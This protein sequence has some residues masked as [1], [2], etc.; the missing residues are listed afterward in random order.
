MA[1]G[2]RVR[3]ECTLWTPSEAP[4]SGFG[5]LWTHTGYGSILRPA[6]VE[7]HTMPLIV[8]GD[9]NVNARGGHNQR[10]L[11]H[12]GSQYGLTLCTDTNEATSRN[13]TTTD[14]IFSRHVHNIQTAACVAYFR[15]QMP[16]ATLSSG[17]NALAAVTWKDFI[18][19]RVKFSEKKAV[20]VTRSIANSLVGAMTGPLLAIFFLG[21]FF[22]FCKRKGVTAGAL[23]GV[24]LASWHALGS[25]AYPRA[26]YGLPT[27]TAGCVDFNQTLTSGSLE[28]PSIPSGPAAG[29]RER[30]PGSAEQPAAEPARAASVEVAQPGGI[31]MFYHISYVWTGCMGFLS[32]LFAGIVVSLVFERS[33]KAQVDPE[34]ICPLVRKLMDNYNPNKTSKKS[35]NA[36]TQDAETHFSRENKFVSSPGR[37][38]SCAL[39]S[40]LSGKCLFD[41]LCYQI[42]ALQ[43]CDRALYVS[44]VE[45]PGF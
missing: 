37:C 17:Y 44:V 28:T 5:D 18:E 16:L 12:F 9:L 21:V 38:K 1:G 27:S 31:L 36:Q 22:P 24:A 14:L 43:I 15:L 39:T 11:E 10:L 25:I 32:A 33:D 19:P 35:E 6:N 45:L 23:I 2:V 8:M 34:H 13:G 4:A 20:F 40:R 29:K 42:L 30:W 3:L 7:H 41:A 26:S